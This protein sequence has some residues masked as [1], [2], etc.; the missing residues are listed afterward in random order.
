MVEALVVAAEGGG[1]GGMEEERACMQADGHGQEVM[2]KF[3]HAVLKNKKTLQPHCVV[4]DFQ[5]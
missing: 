3:S 2:V 1:G 4:A 5:E